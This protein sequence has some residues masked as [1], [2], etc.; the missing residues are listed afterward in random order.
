MI[1]TGQA[2]IHGAPR[3]LGFPNKISSLHVHASKSA[4]SVT[5]QRHHIPPTKLKIG[6]SEPQT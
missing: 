2:S 4:T 6:K 1:W 5:A 3:S